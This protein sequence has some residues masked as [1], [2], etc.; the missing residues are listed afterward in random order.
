MDLPVLSDHYSN[1]YSGKPLII[2]PLKKSWC[3]INLF[4]LS[5]LHREQTGVP[6]PRRGFLGYKHLEKNPQRQQCISPGG[7]LAESCQL[8][9]SWQK[10]ADLKLA[11]A[12]AWTGHGVF[13]HPGSCSTFSMGVRTNSTTQGALWLLVAQAATSC[14]QKPLYLHTQWALSVTFTFTLCFSQV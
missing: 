9:E 5:W 10:S 14:T 1:Q 12:C 8:W 2:I 11:G 3:F 6:A 13:I 7:N 4:L